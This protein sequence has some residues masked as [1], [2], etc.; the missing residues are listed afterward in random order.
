MGTIAGVDNFTTTGNIGVAVL[1][2][3]ITLA[4]NDFHTSAEAAELHAFLTINGKLEKRHLE[5]GP[6]PKSTETFNLELPVGTDISL[7]NTLLIRDMSTDATVGKAK[8]A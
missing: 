2:T 8:I 1:A 5:L 6:I 7:F 4:V 3:G